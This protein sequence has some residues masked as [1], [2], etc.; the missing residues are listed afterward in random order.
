MEVILSHSGQPTWH[1]KVSVR[2]EHNDIP[3]RSSIG[4]REFAE[5]GDKDQVPLILR[6]AQLA[7]LNPGEE[8][9]YFK[10]LDEAQCKSHRVSINFSRNTVVVEITGAD[11]DV[12]FI[13][14]P[15]IIS[16]TERVCYSSQHDLTR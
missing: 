11:V 2:F 5:T 16:N 3:G 13:D 14:L 12:T 15:G 7:I 10:D 4:T 1:C 8:I 9:S 6:R